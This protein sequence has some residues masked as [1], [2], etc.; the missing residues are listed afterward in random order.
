MGF[1]DTY[2]ALLAGLFG[3][4]LYDVIYP[5]WWGGQGKLSEEP[6]TAKVNEQVFRQGS[7]AIGDV[8]IPSWQRNYGATLDVT[9]PK[10]PRPKEKIDVTQMIPAGM[11]SSYKPRTG[12]PKK[13][14][15][16]YNLDESGAFVGAGNAVN[17]NI[18]ND[19]FIPP[20]LAGGR[21][22]HLKMSINYP[23]ILDKDNAKSKIKQL[24][25]EDKRT[26]MYINKEREGLSEDDELENS[27]GE[28]KPE[29][30]RINTSKMGVSLMPTRSKQNPGKSFLEDEKKAEMI[31][32]MGGFPQQESP[33][34]SGGEEK[35]KKKL[36]KK[37]PE[38]VLVEATSGGE[39]NMMPAQ[40][41]P[42]T[43]LKNTRLA[44]HRQPTENK[45]GGVTS[46]GEP[47][48]SPPVELDTD[49][50]QANKPPGL[51]KTSSKPHEKSQYQ[52]NNPAATLGPT[53]HPNPRNTQDSGNFEKDLPSKMAKLFDSRRMDGDHDRSRN[54]A[55]F[56]QPSDN[57]VRG[58]NKDSSFN[59]RPKTPPFQPNMGGK[60]NEMNLAEVLARV[61]TESNAPTDERRFDNIDSNPKNR[62]KT[63]TGQSNQGNRSRNEN[64]A[65]SFARARP[66]DQ[67]VVDIRDGKN[68]RLE[69]SD[70]IDQMNR[71]INNQGNPSKGGKGPYIDPPG[72]SSISN[73]PGSKEDIKKNDG[74]KSHASSKEGKPG[75]INSP[76]FGGSRN[77]EKNSTQN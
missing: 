30:S 52:E 55:E 5:K 1:S 76:H 36:K 31:K 26:K 74:Q 56:N 60:G 14:G 9:I 73:R 62:P 65:D 10:G 59:N 34:T 48:T 23:V 41:S 45:K 29:N 13:R 7:N 71:S 68:F 46:D 67:G 42:T 3:Q 43:K 18:N 39:D 66:N 32:A 27:K 8:A 37:K 58:G 25:D 50:D 16:P 38:E 17:I 11:H 51:G 61:K 77:T 47:L 69:D 20:P 75:I 64:L 15:D 54:N 35:K 53:R 49:N 28:I 4:A 57:Q 19:Q 12:G 70:S 63:P 21:G 22:Q 72:I 44:P 2:T 33:V 40:V 6:I 24:M